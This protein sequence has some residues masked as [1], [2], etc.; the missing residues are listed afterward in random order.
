M[1][2]RTIDFA[3]RDVVTI[4]RGLLSPPSGAAAA[5]ERALSRE[6]DVPHVV[7]AASGRAALGAIVRALELRRGSRVVVPCYTDMSVPDTLGDLDHEARFVDSDPLDANPD[8]RLL[9]P[10]LD[11]SVSAVVTA[12]HFGRVA[13]LDATLAVCDEHGLPLIED[14]THAIGATARGQPVGTFGVAGYL[15]FNFTKPFTGF[16]GGAVLTADVRFAAAVRQALALA[17][18]EPRAAT[19]KRAL[20]GAALWLATRRALFTLTAYPLLTG[21]ARRGGDLAS[22]YQAVA[23]RPGGTASWGPISELSARV[24]LDH[25]AHL[26]ADIDRRRALADALDDAL[27]PTIPRLRDRPATRGVAY[28]YVILAERRAEL[29][30]R[31]LGAGIDTG[32]H[33]MHD[34]GARFDPRGEF[35]VARR[36]LAESIQ[37]PI[38]AGVRPGDIE[39]VARVARAFEPSQ[40]PA[41]NL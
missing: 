41:Q 9:P 20:K 15:S 23:N 40:R 18:P 24:A 16:G 29:A 28:F 17:P 8:A 32:H 14:A 36:L 22:S 38:H 1:A 39:R 25:V 30:R 33:L 10:L 11:A 7:T 4:A 6:L 35:P 31:L 13:D 34:N 19:V 5:L 27:P 3:P 2:R 12:H 37:I 21:L 26:R